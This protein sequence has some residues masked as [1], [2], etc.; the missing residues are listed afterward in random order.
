MT[1]DNDLAAWGE[2]PTTPAEQ[3][4]ADRLAEALERLGRGEPVPPPEQRSLD[5]VQPLEQA[6]T[7]FR[8]QAGL[9]DN[10]RTLWPPPQT[11]PDPFPGEFR[12][13]RRL[14][15]G[16]YGDVWLAEEIHVGGRLV[17]LKTLKS[18]GGPEA[19]S[20]LAALRREA[21]ILGRLSHRNIVPVYAWRES[22]TNPGFRHCLVLR[23]VAGGSLDRR[24][25][26]GPLPWEEAA[27]FVAD[28]AE[29]LL[30]VHERGIIHRDIKPAN[31]L[32]SPLAPGGR[33]VGGEG[34]E[35]AL[36]TDFGI[37]GRLGQAGGPAGTPRF[38]APEAFI[39]EI[40]PKMD[41]FSLAATL[42]RLVTDAYPF[43]L[44]PGTKRIDS[45]TVA[46]LLEQ[47]ER[48]LPD[49]DPRCAGLPQPL[50]RLIR[51][52]L[53][54]DSEQRP[55]LALFQQGLRA[56]LNLVLADSLPQI[57]AAA[58][59]APVQLHLRVSRQVGPDTYRPVATRGARPDSLTR[60]MK[61]VPRPPEQVPLRTD[62]RVRIEVLADQTGYVTVFN[63]GPTGD[64]N[65]LF[66][67]EP[68][69]AGA[70]PTVWA[71]QPLHVLDVEMQPP[72]GRERLFAVW[73][74]R[75]LMLSLEQLHGAVQKGEVPLSPSY[76]AT[77]NMVKV[78][79]SVA[80]LPAGEWHAVVLEVE[81]AP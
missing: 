65:L 64:L 78:K 39:G 67:D 42:Y 76:Q 45:Q 37:A 60:N 52:G 49:P 9:L 20:Q 11:L 72:A 19:A 79:Q 8:E 34:I 33:G 61:K 55:D 5:E 36:L 23:Y 69:A 58:G 56:A 32:L 46:D 40:S 12:I 74:A 68:V 14:G 48:G 4:D 26:A 2:P 54:A 38:M 73:S 30:H 1:T 66:P 41:V 3:A 22:P 59:P 44:P 53:A 24:L 15:R 6:A 13:L 27:R 7:L 28:V 50:E 18:A 21:G 16:A 70:A 80:Q 29:G 43:P 17:A 57:G 75:P 77:R 51:A 25:E 10:N 62:D 71:N 31:I 47:I 63:V 35:E 81:H